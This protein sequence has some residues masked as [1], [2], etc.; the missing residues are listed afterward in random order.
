[1]LPKDPALKAISDKLPETSGDL[2]SPPTLCRF[3][4]MVT[5]KDLR[6]L[7]DGLFELHLKTHPDPRDVIVPDIECVIHS[8]GV[9]DFDRDG[10]SDVVIAEMHQGKDPDEVVL[11]LNEGRGAAWRKQVLSSEGSHDIAVGDIGGDGDLDIVGANHGGASH[12]L[13][14]WQQER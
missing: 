14:L 11:Y 9:G 6:K 8:L 5:R 12:P 3:E 10:D 4:N 7:A 1:M 13:E 2:V